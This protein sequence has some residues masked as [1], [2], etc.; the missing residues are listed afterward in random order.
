MC[1][2]AELNVLLRARVELPV[3]LELATGEFREG[4]NFLRSGGASG[5]ER[6]IG[7]RGWHFIRIADAS[8]RSGVGESPQEAIAGALKLALRSIG[9]FFNGVEV[10]PI[11]LTRYPW[12]ILARVGVYPF[13]IQQTE[14][15]PVPDDAL[16]VP[17]FARKRRLPAGAPWPA[18]QYRCA[19][20][21]LRQTLVESRRR[22][23]RPQ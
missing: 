17:A 2:I 19:M 3:G 18:P 8:L 15:Q 16:P 14:V 10:G 22:G 13:R 7:M 5:L 23:S 1:K 6:K 11:Q 21:L 4:W 20:P 9:E 12:F